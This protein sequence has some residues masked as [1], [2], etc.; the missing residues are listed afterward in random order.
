MLRAHFIWP[1]ALFAAVSLVSTQPRDLDPVGVN[2]SA[3][4]AFAGIQPNK[5]VAFRHDTAWAQ[6]PVQVDERAM[7]S[8]AQIRQKPAFSVSTLVYTDALT[9]TG[10]DP[11]PTFDA[12]DEL[13]FMAR[14]AG[15]FAPA[16]RPKGVRSS[17]PAQTVAVNDPLGGPVRYVYL[18]ESDGTLN[19]GAGKDLATYTYNL[20]GGAYK[21]T[22]NLSGNNPE[23][24][25]GR[26]AAYE[27]H[28]SDR[29]ILDRFRILARGSSGVD[30]LDRHKFQF[31]PGNCNR[32]TNTFSAGGGAMIANK[33]GP[34]R[35]IRSVVGANSGGVT[36]RDWYLYEGRLDIV[37]FLR[38]HA[39]GSTFFFYDFSPAATGMKNHDNLNRAG[40]TI[41]GKPD[42]VKAGFME[43]QFVTG[44][45]GSLTTAFRR[46][47]DITKMVQSSYYDDDIAP[48]WN[49]CTGDAFAYAA[50]GPTTGGLPNTDPLR[51]PANHLTVHRINYFDPPGVT[52]AQAEAR[53]NAARNPLEART[54]WLANEGG[55]TP[56]A[57]VHLRL[58][59]GDSIGLPLQVGASFGPGPIAIDTRK[60]HL[61]P[62]ALL[63]LSV[64]GTAP[65]VFQGFAGRIDDRGTAAAAL[66]IPAVPALKGIP[67]H[68]AFVT[69]D[70]AAPSGIRSISPPHTL[71]IQ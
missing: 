64:N 68:L 22:Y 2:G 29:W 40:V 9:W 37:T 1:A 47:T 21:T 54:E 44:A 50:S 49:Q 66:A 70:G 11:V 61:S 35:A 48:S 19:P 23:N 41:D 67:L 18:F 8:F 14:D 24:S 56:G 57:T 7:V 32:T 39:I 55:G 43:W 15:G 20:L 5:I 31:A 59:A 10:A 38:V 58:V 51:G 6:I 45:Q 13:V 46:D 27:V 62:D 69:L 30:I 53:A 25:V 28:F 34:V 33:D 60:L 65:E 16:G 42:A 63:W 26:G 12:D 3:L 17:G 4:P 71:R 36:Q 52:V